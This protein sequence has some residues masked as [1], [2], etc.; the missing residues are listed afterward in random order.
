MP[1]LATKFRVQI[2]FLWGAKKPPPPCVTRT[3]IY[4][5]VF[6]SAINL[7]DI[8]TWVNIE[9]LNLNKNPT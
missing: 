8:C 1:N 6:Y 9:T 2:G 3:Q 5:Y 4:K 7:P